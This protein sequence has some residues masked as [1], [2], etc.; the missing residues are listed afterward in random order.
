MLEEEHP[1]QTSHAYYT[2]DSNYTHN[3]YYKWTTVHI[4]Y[5]LKVIVSKYPLDQI[6][7]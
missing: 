1:H 2:H 5:I 4:S 7:I 3:T 6:F